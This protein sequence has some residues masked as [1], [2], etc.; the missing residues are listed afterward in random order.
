MIHLAGKRIFV[1]GAG[2]GMGAAVAL[3]S[4]RAGAEVLATDKFEDGLLPL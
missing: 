4:T 3:L 2:A 1:S